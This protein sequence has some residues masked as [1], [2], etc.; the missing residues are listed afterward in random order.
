MEYTG[1]KN[2]RAATAPC[3]AF[4]RSYDVSPYLRCRISYCQ[5]GGIQFAGHLNGR[6]ARG[7]FSR[8]TSTHV[9]T[10]SMCLPEHKSRRSAAWP[11]R[12]ERWF[13]DAYF[14][15]ASPSA[16]LRGPAIRGTFAQFTRTVQDFP[17]LIQ[18]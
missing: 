5:P 13:S 8:H 18:A 7:Y 3:V 14:L 16:V 1:G 15:Y 11:R 2:W 9:P 12:P 17:A 4:A 6:G 10:P